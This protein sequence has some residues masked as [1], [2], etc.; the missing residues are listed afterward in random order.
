M[1]DVVLTLIPLITSLSYSFTET[2]ISLLDITIGKLVGLN[3]SSFSRLK[4]TQRQKC[5]Q[6]HGE[7]ETNYY[8]HIIHTRKNILHI[9]ELL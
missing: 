1:E 3:P 5:T 4:V 8:Q 2:Q 6:P 7:M 9:S